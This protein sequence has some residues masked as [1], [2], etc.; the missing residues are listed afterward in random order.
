MLFF[1]FHLSVS[2]KQHFEFLKSVMGILVCILDVD[3]V[4]KIR[5]NQRYLSLT[6]QSY[7]QLR[8][9]LE[10]HQLC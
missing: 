3:T 8:C 5:A 9:L 7:L 2:L 6:M 1:S 4:V 10:F